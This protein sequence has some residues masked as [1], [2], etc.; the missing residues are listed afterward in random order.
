M[1]AVHAGTPPIATLSTVRYEGELSTVICSTHDCMKGTGDG[2]SKTQT[3][4]YSP[5]P[6]FNIGD[7]QEYTHTHTY[8]RAHTHARATTKHILGTAWECETGP[9]Y[10]FLIEFW[11]S[12]RS[13]LTIFQVAGGVFAKWILVWK[14]TYCFTVSL[15]SCPCIKI[16]IFHVWHTV[17][18][19]YTLQL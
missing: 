3:T 15:R 12:C 16:N 2:L 10:T 19:L 5:S 8:A 14:S 6:I 13:C 11:S 1:A 4:T 17:R 9:L 18:Q 7:K